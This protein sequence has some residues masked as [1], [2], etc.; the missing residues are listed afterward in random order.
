MSTLS[1]HL[2]VTTDALSIRPKSYRLRWLS[3]A[4]YGGLIAV[5]ATVALAWLG[6]SRDSL[7]VYVLIAGLTSSISGFAAIS[8]PT[9]RLRRI[10]RELRVEGIGG[11]ARLRIVADGQLMDAGEIRQVRVAREVVRWIRYW[12]PGYHLLLVFRTHVLLIDTFRETGEG[13]E[14][15]DTATHTAVQ[16]ASVLNAPLNEEPRVKNYGL[17]LG[18]PSHVLTPWLLP[19]IATFVLTFVIGL[20]DS[21]GVVAFTTT[22]FIVVVRAAVVILERSAMQ[23]M[24]SHD[25]RLVDEFELDDTPPAAP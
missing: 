4:H 3:Q 6:V 22:C 24:P 14:A 25:A 16:L 21:F 12:V 9:P 11:T 17:T 18:F 20:S 15:R 1:T 7:S 8:L 19:A 2:N 23:L 13:N 5:A 10:E